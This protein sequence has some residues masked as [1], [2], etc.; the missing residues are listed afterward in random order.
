MEKVV[1]LTSQEAAEKLARDGRNEIPEKKTPFTVKIIK[2]FLSP[3]SLM[4]LLASGLS[5]F[6]GKTFDGSFILLL[7]GIN[8]G[9]ATWQE[10]KADNAIKKLNENLIGWV[11]VLHDD[12]WQE[13]DTRQLV[14]GDIIQL[15][16]GEIVP[17]DA[18]LLDNK[19]VSVNE[20]ALT[21]ESLPKDKNVNYPLYSGS[22]IASGIAVVKITATGKNTK[23]GKTIFSVEGPK[24][25]SFLEQD[26]IRISKFLSVLSLLGVLILSTFFILQ[27]F[28]LVELLTLDLSLVIA[29]IPVSLP[30]VMTL[31]IALGILDLSKKQ[32]IVRRLSALEDLANVNL[33]LTDKTGTLTE[34]KIVIDTIIPYN[35]YTNKQVI[36]YAYLASYQD[37]RNLISLAISQKAQELSAILT[38]YTVYTFVPGDS[39]K[40]RTT[41]QV[42][43]GEGKIF[44]TA[45]APQVI[46]E[47]CSLSTQLTSA[48]NK[49]IAD[50]AHQGYRTLAVAIGQTEKDMT[51]LG[52]LTLS[53]HL[54]PE[55]ADVIQFLKDNHIDVAMVTGD[56]R[57]IAAEIARKLAI[58]GSGIVTKADLEKS[59]WQGLDVNFYKNTQA[60]AE[61]FPEDKLRLVQEAKRY[62]VVAT[63]GDG[64]NDLPAVKAANVGFAVENAVIALKET[65]DIVLLANGISVIKDA[66]IEGRKIFARLYSYSVYR[67]SESFRLIITI[68]LLGL[69]YKS[70]PLTPLQIILIA[71][72]NDIPIISLAY[73]RVTQTNAPAKLNV[74]N[75][76]VLSSLFGLVGVANSLILFILL[77][78]VFHVALPIVQT[79]YFLKLTVS[80]HLLIYVAHTKER[81][82]KFL[83]SKQV[84]LATTITQLFATFLAFSGLFMPAKLPTFYILL[85][86]LWAFGWMQIGEIVKVLQGKITR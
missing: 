12:K 64:I 41:V 47:L 78:S 54:R 48:V 79:I 31:I 15:A 75:R 14:T 44:I 82:W 33:L 1:G 70:Y 60:F 24:G 2:Q 22:F 57:V 68:V 62:F 16:A 45:G 49:D 38:D 66:I 76:F 11:K 13:I 3:I 9:V 5:F 18:T 7:L 53:D 61:I 52:L 30:T 34:N 65:A 8:T 26:I 43:D 21:G 55:A 10:A 42:K 23:F 80:G 35:H 4:L 32:V 69:I 17:A 39:V 84:I 63:N 46:L 25:K 19:N 86:W 77:V 74:K 50:L 20:S 51:L 29:G 85:V 71:V 6:S 27:H 58:P 81:W 37:N 72:L 83:P 28:P 67:L 56:N 73:D 40:K 36:S 59:H